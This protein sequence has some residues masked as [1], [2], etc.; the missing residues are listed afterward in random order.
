MNLYE[1]KIEQLP[2]SNLEQKKY[3]VQIPF[4]Y[5]PVLLELKRKEARI[6]K[7]FLRI[8]LELVDKDEV[9]LSLLRLF[10]SPEKIKSTDGMVLLIYTDKTIEIEFCTSGLM[11]EG[12][13]EIGESVLSF[14]ENMPY[15]RIAKADCRE[16]VIVLP[17]GDGNYYMNLDKKESAAEKRLSLIG[18]PQILKNHYKWLQD[19][20]YGK[21]ISL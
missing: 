15:I 4:L 13:C 9:M 10:G 2:D 7:L 16:S 1:I 18:N 3:F 12:T 8:N 17:E 5:S 19:Q 20:F 21:V 14:S 6:R 11:F